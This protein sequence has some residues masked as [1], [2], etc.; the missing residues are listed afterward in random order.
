PSDPGGDALLDAMAAAGAGRF[1]FASTRLRS[2]FDASATLPV[3]KAPG[4]F[5]LAPDAVPPGPAI[6]L[7]QPYGAAMAE[8]SGLVNIQRARD[9]LL[10]DVR[11]YESAGGWAVP[12]LALRLA[13]AAGA[14][15]RSPVAARGGDL[16][17]NWRERSHLPFAS[18]AD[19]IEG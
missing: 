13:Q 18:A 19:L 15:V 2:D 4:A 3:A 14:D 8:H 7:I 5:R 12:S 10:R 6:A 9:G 11:L 17:I 1:I 16:R